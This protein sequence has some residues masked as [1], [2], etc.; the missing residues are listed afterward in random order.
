M[1]GRGGIKSRKK[2]RRHK[3]AVERCSIAN[4]GGE[5]KGKRFWVRRG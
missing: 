1:E 3:R 2:R 4:R 5:G